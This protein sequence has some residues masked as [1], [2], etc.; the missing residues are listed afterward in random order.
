MA[1][2]VTGGLLDRW[3]WFQQPAP[4]TSCLFCPF[5][6]I[7]E[8][9]AARLRPHPAFLPIFVYPG[10]TRCQ[11]GDGQLRPHPAFFAH[12]WLSGSDALPSST[13]IPPFCPFWRCRKHELYQEL[14]SNPC[15]WRLIYSQ[16]LQYQDYEDDPNSL[17]SEKQNKARL[18][19]KKMQY[20]IP[21]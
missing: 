19:L 4:P 5:S 7:R 3:A 2:W 14:E 13:H 20:I 8:W 10:V 18:E 12:F 21:N 6:I 11:D 1:T 17:V 16:H 9:R 15:Q